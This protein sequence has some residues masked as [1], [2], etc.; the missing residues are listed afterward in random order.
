MTKNEAVAE[1]AAVEQGFENLYMEA[2][3]NGGGCWWCCGGGDEWHAELT[4][5]RETVLAAH[6]DL[7]RREVGSGR[8]GAWPDPADTSTEVQA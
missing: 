2:D 1:L 5:R 6:P 8:G 4:A 3:R 7:A